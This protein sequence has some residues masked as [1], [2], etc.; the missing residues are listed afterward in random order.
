MTV[1]FPSHTHPKSLPIAIFVQAEGILHAEPT[2]FILGTIDLGHTE[3]GLYQSTLR[4]LPAEKNTAETKSTHCACKDEKRKFRRACSKKQP[5]PK[6]NTVFS[7]VVI[8][9]HQAPQQPESP[10]THGK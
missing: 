7:H 9:D 2:S 1:I 5:W 10:E 6:R 8:K 3:V 4:P